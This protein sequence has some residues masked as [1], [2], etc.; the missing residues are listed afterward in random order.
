M[1]LVMD[2]VLQ[3]DTPITPIT[4]MILSFAKK[5]CNQMY[6]VYGSS[7]YVLTRVVCVSSVLIDEIKRIIKTSEILKCVSTCFE[8]NVY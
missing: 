3:R 8:D 7:G 6:T 2:A 4:G 1:H 5:V